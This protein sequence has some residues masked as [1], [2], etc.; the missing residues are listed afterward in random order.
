M[1]HQLYPDLVALGLHVLSGASEERTLRTAADEESPSWRGTR[2]EMILCDL[3]AT[4][5]AMCR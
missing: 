4:G 5:A 3:Y 1:I 2:L